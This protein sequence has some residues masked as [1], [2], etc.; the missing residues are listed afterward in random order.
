[1]ETQENAHKIKLI[2]LW[3]DRICFYI[4]VY[5]NRCMTLS[6]FLQNLYCSLVFTKGIQLLL[7]QAR[8]AI[9]LLFLKF[10]QKACHHMKSGEIM[11]KK[12][13]LPW[14]KK[15]GTFISI[16]KMEVFPHTQ[17]KTLGILKLQKRLLGI[18]FSH[19]F[20]TYLQFIIVSANCPQSQEFQDKN[21]HDFGPFLDVYRSFGWQK[22]HWDHTTVLAQLAC[23]S[24]SHSQKD[25]R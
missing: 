14:C 12:K 7:N 19:S 21:I 5:D 2:V 3:H 13:K 18:D 8:K 22:Y 6:N 4:L 23:Q 9:N 11:Q 16:I 10:L 17:K 25:T 1:M 20:I 15:I 24:W